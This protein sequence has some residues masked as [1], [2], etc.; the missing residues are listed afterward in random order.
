MFGQYLVQPL[1]LDA[2]IEGEGRRTLLEVLQ[3]HSFKL[4]CKFHLQSTTNKRV[5]CS[6]YNLPLDVPRSVGLLIPFTNNNE[7]YNS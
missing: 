2:F 4:L 5:K 3:T 1:P 7:A 6:S